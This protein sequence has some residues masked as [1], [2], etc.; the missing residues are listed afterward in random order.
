MTARK[1]IGP[2]RI[3][4]HNNQPYSGILPLR[5]MKSS[6]NTTA[7]SVINM[8]KIT[9]KSKARWMMTISASLGRSLAATLFNPQTEAIRNDQ[10]L[11]EPTLLW[12]I[13]NAHQVQWHVFGGIVDGFHGS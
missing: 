13:R 1:A 10:S 3:M 9:I 12:H 6:Q 4:P 11:G 8:P 7:T 2:H 5:T